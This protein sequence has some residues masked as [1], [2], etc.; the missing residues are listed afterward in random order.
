MAVRLSRPALDLGVVTADGGPMLAFYRD[1][2]G[3]E[4]EGETPFPGLGRVLRL[5]CG[6]SRVKLLVLERPPRAEA[7]GGG[8]SAATGYRYC[9]LH[10]AN[11]DEIV[12]AC[13]DADHAVPVAPRQ[14]RPGVRVAMLED[15]DGNTV[16][17][18][19]G[20]S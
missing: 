2:L 5:R 12:R 7:P 3:F 1:L 15:P 17:L 19:E 13:R 10:V 14:L 16:E 9:T 4:S 6:E 20:A 8:F 11:L 18:M